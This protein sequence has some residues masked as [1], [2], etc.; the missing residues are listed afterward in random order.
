M[1]ANLVLPERP[2]IL[3]ITLRRLGDVLLTTPL[4][5]TLRRRWPGAWLDTLV[6]RGSDGILQGNPDLDG[7]LTMPQRPSVRE[8]LAIMGQL[9]R[10]YD[11][12]IST[13]AGDRPTFYAWVAGR[14]RVGLLPFPGRDGDW[15][16]R[17][18]HHRG[19]QADPE[20]HRVEE[21]RQFAR[22][23]GIESWSD[24]VCPQGAS[25]DG[26]APDGPYAVLHANPMFRYRRWSDEGWRGLARGL[27][28]RG[29]SVVA[30]EGPDPEERAYLDALWGG[31]G[32]PIIR[33]QLDWA[34]LT[35][36]LQDAAV[37]VGPDTSVTHLAAASGCPTVA[38]YGP[39]RPKQIG[40]WPVGGLTQ[41]WSDV[42]TIQRRGNVWLVQ[43]PLP[44]MP[45]DKLGCERHLNSHSQCLDDLSPHQV[46]AAVDQALAAP[47]QAPFK[48]A[49]EGG[50][51]VQTPV[52]KSLLQ[53]QT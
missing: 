43:N 52:S 46:L 50:A 45:C 9:W 22:A 21:L 15:W 11:L 32:V 35:A 5:R 23:L 49:V 27:V 20:M 53:Q 44:C 25:A 37:Y 6:F 12:V 40:P 48:A 24:L 28:M 42:G 51:A 26:I 3:V 2:R 13:Q 10:R 14:F 30:T 38:L 16:K 47:R 8:S 31:A 1:A 7:V 17:F 41:P 34:G 39:A 18:I 36:L 19:V 4:L 29:L 33:V